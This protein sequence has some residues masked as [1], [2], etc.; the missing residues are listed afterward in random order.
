M[1]V[2]EDVYGVNPIDYFLYLKREFFKFRTYHF[3]ILLVSITSVGSQFS[4]IKLLLF[5]YFQL[6]N[7][8]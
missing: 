4:I 3:P 2:R 8:L 5:I 6:P 7:C 1:Y